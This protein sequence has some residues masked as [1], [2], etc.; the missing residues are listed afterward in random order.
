[1][2]LTTGS[3]IG[4]YEV[5][6]P[7]G[8][9]GMGEVYRARDTRLGR[10]VAL[11]VLPATFAGDPD[12]LMRFEREAKTLASLNHPHIAQIYGLEQSAETLA[13]VM[14]LVDG[15]DLAA[16]LARG[17]LPAD[18]ALPIA[19]Q[20]AEALE[21]AHEQGIVHR[22]LKPANVKVRPDGTVKV[23]D[24]GLAKA[25]DG[26]AADED[27][28]AATITSPAVTA[29][30]VILGTAAYMAPEQA[31]GTP[32]DKRADIWAFGVVLFEMLAGR[33]PF[34]E[35]TVSD[36]IAAV[37]REDVPW[38]AL[39]AET[40]APIRHLL[41]R[42]LARDPRKRLRDIGDADVEGLLAPG[43]DAG[44]AHASR[45]A[46]RVRPSWL[47][48]AASLLLVG[49]AAAGVA[50]TAR[51]PREPPARRFTLL[52]EDDA[53]PSAS[54]ISPDGEY[55]AYATTQRVWLRRFSDAEAR[56]VPGSDGARAVF[57][58]PD[59]AWLGFQA[60]GQLWKVA[61]A[62]ES[63]PVAIARV[64]ADFTAFGGA[65]WL[66]DGR[67]LFVT[68]SSG[69][70][71]VSSQG[72]EPR[73]LL[74]VDAAKETDFHQV[75]ALPDGRRVL[76]VTHPVDASA[77]YT[78]EVFDGATRQTLL[79][80][81]GIAGPV[82]ASSGHLLYATERGLW[83]VAFDLSAARTSGE[84]FLLQPDVY[85]P[86]VASDGTLVL[87][88]A[89]GGVQQELVWLDRSGQ[90]GEP[91]SRQSS[92]M[93][94]IRL[95]PDGRRAAA[96]V[97]T[98]GNPDVWV[99]DTTRRDERR[100][101]FEPE[102]DTSPGWV[103]NGQVIAYACGTALCVRGVDGATP[104][105]T[106]LADN[107]LAV[108]ATPDGGH[109]LLDRRPEGAVADVFRLEVDHGG[110]PAPGTGPT[111][112][113]PGPRIQALADVSPDGRHIAYQSNESG[114][115]AIY[116][117]RFPSGE[118][119]W[120]VSRGIGY[121]PRWSAAGDRLFF[122]DDLSR[123]VEVDVTATPAFSV[124]PRRIAVD[125]RAAGANPGRD[126]FDRSL[127]GQRFLVARSPVEA[128]RQASI[129]VVENWRAAFRGAPE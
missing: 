92:G 78:I 72:G 79:T 117:A 127:D 7:L 26:A 40:P 77:P 38:D 59:S 29:R 64:P 37:L 126:G 10:E 35:E 81:Q 57:W 4:V 1:M 120:D 98:G 65:T 34:R 101:T 80:G 129:Y 97:L 54:A 17:P 112:L 93:R 45:Q 124:G 3:R 36:T 115:F 66:A 113:V 20:I 116:V 47:A 125:A 51:T 52:T 28:G 83:A 68:G 103:A 14:E 33:P 11:K 61:A 18:E 41:R 121:R 9:G 5:L 122:V 6:A 49:A 32:V 22:D 118:G 85:G 95:S 76:F 46:R 102:P 60:Q 84:P 19:R 108:A 111:P 67:I 73:V 110:V 96:A 48:W 88:P 71:E 91:L 30:G 8:A 42:C 56:P 43:A 24:F 104:R 89:S 44:D 100:L 114:E 106:V 39:P 128:R 23:L 86:S 16:R 27:D 109:L 63:A 90:P 62:S 53:P 69:L 58:S 94:G 31:R 70:Y 107:V 123:I 74:A 2:R 75:R 99:Y 50:W 25:L 21:A 15:E 82:Y 105:Q 87:L 12:R 13:L 55:L 119:K